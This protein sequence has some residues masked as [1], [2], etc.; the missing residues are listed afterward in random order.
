MPVMG[1]LEACDRIHKEYPEIKI[2]ILTMN[3]QPEMVELLIRTGAHGFLS[4]SV[5]PDEVYKA[6]ND[7]MSHGFYT[8]DHVFHALRSSSRS[9]GNSGFE[10]LTNRE[11]EIIRLICEELTMKEIANKLHISE[12]TVQ[13]HRTN[14]MTKIKVTNTAGLV[15]YAVANKIITILK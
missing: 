4:K 10:S 8:N 2:V 7:V 9:K 11:I 12:K 6:L 5:E 3:D 14:I 1:G 13:N 15:K